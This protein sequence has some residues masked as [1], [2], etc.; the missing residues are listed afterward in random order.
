VVCRR[1]CRDAGV[2]ESSEDSEEEESSGRA[3]LYTRSETQVRGAR[4][5][6][7][8]K[9]RGLWKL[10]ILPSLG[11]RREGAQEEQQQPSDRIETDL[12]R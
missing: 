8:D 6:K 2:K 11:R 10:E 9:G 7:E 3:A 5:E 4:R 1:L 12:D